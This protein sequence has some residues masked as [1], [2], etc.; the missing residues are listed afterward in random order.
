[1]GGM[2]AQIPI[3]DD[4]ERNAAADREGPRRQAREARAGHD[5]TVGRAPGLVGVAREEFDLV[6]G[7]RPNQLESCART[8]RSPRRTC[9]RCLQARSPRRGCARTSRSGVRYLDAWLSGNGCV[10]IHDLMETPATAEI[11]RAQVWQWQRTAR[12]SRTGAR[13]TRPS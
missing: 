7:S 3:K 10:P 4:P 1:M 8:S 11:S 2:P 6:L 12:D 9:S 13:S 5:G